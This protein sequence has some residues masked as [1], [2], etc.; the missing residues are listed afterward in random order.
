MSQNFVK[1]G[2][3]GFTIF[4]ETFVLTVWK[5][6]LCD[7]ALF[8]MFLHMSFH[9]INSGPSIFA[10]W[11]RAFV[12]CVNLLKK[13]MKYIQSLR[14]LGV[15]SASAGENCPGTQKM[16][17]AGDPHQQNVRPVNAR[18][19]NHPQIFILTDFG[20]GSPGHLQTITLDTSDFL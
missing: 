16:C 18:T 11:N 12:L 10:T 4:N 20:C 17:R 9:V 19:Q 13:I 5:F 6:F 7:I 2:F 1:S 8:H 15:S 3:F 14:I